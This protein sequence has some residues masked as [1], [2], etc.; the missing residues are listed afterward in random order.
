FI[1]HIVLGF[2]MLC[3]KIMLLDY[4]P[5]ETAMALKHIVLSHH[6]KKEFGSPVTPYFYEAELIAKADEKSAAAQHWIDAI[7]TEYADGGN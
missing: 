1:G 4:F 2:E 3:E 5:N 6:G 7:N